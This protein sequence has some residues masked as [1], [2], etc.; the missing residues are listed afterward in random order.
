[1]KRMFKKYAH[2]LWLLYFPLYLAA[3]SFIEN[4]GSQKI[5]II[6]TT[7]DQKLPFIEYFIIP[8]Y[9]WFIYIA[10]GVTYFLF[11]E[12]EP[13]FNV[14]KEAITEYSLTLTEIG[15]L[16]RGEDV[17][18]EDG[19]VVKASEA[20]YKPYSPRSYAYVSDTAPF[21]ELSSWVKGVDL[22]YHEA[23]YV[24]EFADKAA[25]RHHST[26]LQAATVAKEAGVGQL[27]VG[28][29]SSRCKDISLFEK[30]CKSIF[31]SSHA[32]S[33]GDLFDLPM[34]DFQGRK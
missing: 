9:M 34:K 25:E 26:T 8:Y 5:H 11:R 13:Q 32:A 6:E 21:P 23:T 33:D 4:H 22:L 3:F 28:H 2:C 24:Q 12:K 27:V 10:V 1:M 7:L 18:R 14:R 16:K 19:S 31:P 17:I 30:E 20:A 15:T 29:Y